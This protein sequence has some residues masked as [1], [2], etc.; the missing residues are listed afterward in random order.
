M[1]HHTSDN[2]R[3]KPAA[4]WNTLKDELYVI[5]MSPMQKLTA[6][7][8]AITAI[9]LTHFS[10]YLRISASFDSRNDAGEFSAINPA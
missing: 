10:R 6:H 4:V 2:V 9:T 8:A 1:I 3:I 7:T 5:M